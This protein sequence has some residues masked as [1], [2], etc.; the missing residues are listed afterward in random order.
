VKILVKNDA[1]ALE[2][3]T[4]ECLMHIETAKRD[5]LYLV[6]HTSGARPLRT[7]DEV[8]YQSPNYDPKA[9]KNG[10]YRWLYD[11]EVTMLSIANNKDALFLLDTEE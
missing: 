8:L 10:S 7:T 3:E 2:G 9:H 11:F 6:N 4:V 1:Y 5:Q